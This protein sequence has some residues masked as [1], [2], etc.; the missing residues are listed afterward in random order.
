MR[1][2]DDLPLS[3]LDFHVL[4]VLSEGALYGYAVMKAVEKHSRGRVAPEIGSLYRVL[5]RLMG[6]ELVEETDT[7]EEAEESHPGRARKYYRLTE[8]GREVARAEARRL[9]EV[10]ELAREHRLL[11]EGGGG[12]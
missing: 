5:A 2:H 11:P 7:P 10:L 3:A 8:R 4:V 9:R 12:P 1:E 6:Q